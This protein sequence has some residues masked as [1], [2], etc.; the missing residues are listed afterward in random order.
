[1]KKIAIVTALLLVG[2]APEP[3]QE[4]VRYDGTTVEN[5]APFESREAVEYASGAFL[6]FRR[7]DLPLSEGDA[8]GEWVVGWT[9]CPFGSV[10]GGTLEELPPRGGLDREVLTFTID[11][12]PDLSISFDGIR[13]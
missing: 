8:Q 1:M 12:Y 5:R 6:R 11:V 2:C 13:D 10:V 4:L 7:C 9:P 3:A